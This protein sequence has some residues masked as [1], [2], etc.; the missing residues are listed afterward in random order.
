MTKF[1]EQMVNMMHDSRRNL[2]EA[3]RKFMEYTDTLTE[4]QLREKRIT[5]ADR[6]EMTRLKD[7]ADEASKSYREILEAVHNYILLLIL[8][9]EMTLN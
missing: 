9:N 5:I 7:E 2:F 1:E 4:K 8:S 3:D 6:E